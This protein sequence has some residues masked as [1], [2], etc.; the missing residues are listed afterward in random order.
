MIG[1]IIH[2][3][4]NDG[5]QSYKN[6]IGQVLLDKHP[7]QDM[8]LNKLDKINSVFRYFSFDV[9]AKRN[10][11]ISTIVQANENGFKYKMDFAKVYWNP[12]LQ[13]EH[14]RI[15]KL[16]ND[17]DIVYDVF[18]G[19]GPFV[20]PAASKLKH[21]KLLANDLNPESYNYLN[22][23]IKLN[24]VENNLKSFNLDGREFI[25]E[26]VKNDLIENWL[27]SKKSNDDNK[28]FHVIMNLPAMAIE[29]LDAFAGL[30]VDKLDEEIINELYTNDKLKMP[31]IYCY[32]FHQTDEDRN[33]M[34]I[35][36]KNRLNYDK[37]ADINLT[38]VRKVAPAKDMFRITFRLPKEVLFAEKPNKR[39]KLISI[40]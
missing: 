36:V 26:I 8:V 33:E 2:L 27:K 38:F 5:Y 17:G 9:L 35:N 1:H 6:L 29:F 16:L 12:R 39:I 34:I 3:N 37:L 4:L 10:E 7:S 11:S 31:I 40:D 21:C 14:D 20:I 32:C 28:Q 19:I 13:T 25:S 24:K 30:T 22:V 23:N 15:V 18:A